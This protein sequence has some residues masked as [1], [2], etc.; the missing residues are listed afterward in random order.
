MLFREPHEGNKPARLSAV[1]C[2]LN[3]SRR[4]EREAKKRGRAAAGGSVSSRDK[5]PNLS[6]NQQAEQMCWRAGKTGTRRRGGM[7]E[8]KEGERRRRC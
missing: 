5:L 7:N 4:E 8:G 1:P 6:W 3:H 2:L